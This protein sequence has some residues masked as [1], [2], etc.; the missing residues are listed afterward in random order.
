MAFDLLIYLPDRI[1]NPD[2]TA[3]PDLEQTNLIE[4]IHQ[5]KDSNFY[6]T[7][8]EGVDIDLSKCKFQLSVYPDEELDNVITKSINRNQIDYGKNKK[9]KLKKTCI[10]TYKLLPKVKYYSQYHIFV[11]L[12]YGNKAET[13]RVADYNN[14]GLLNNFFYRGEFAEEYYSFI[15]YRVLSV[16]FFLCICALELIY[17]NYLQKL[18]GNTMDID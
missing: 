7:W 5:E 14:I 8:N 13:E 18:I 9:G 6:I 3:R 1:D 10:N 15:S 2:F 17:S 12:L 4:G 11:T 16:L